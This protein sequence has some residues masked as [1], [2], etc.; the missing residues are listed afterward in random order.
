MAKI[1]T[2]L[3]RLSRSEITR[4][5][6]GR[7]DWVLAGSDIRIYPDRHYGTARHARLKLFHV[8]VFYV[9]YV[10]FPV[11]DERQTGFLFP[12]IGESRRDGTEFSVPFYW[13]IEIGR[14]S[15]RERR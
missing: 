7:K 14:A 5:E 12:A 13:N 2:D 4:G 15:C 3:F 10:R 11:G 6:P 1:G 8:P 9:P